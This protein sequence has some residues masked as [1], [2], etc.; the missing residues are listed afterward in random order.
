MLASTDPRC[1]SAVSTRGL[2]R[3]LLGMLAAACAWSLQLGAAQAS[4]TIAGDLDLHVP[5]SINGVGTGGG[6]GIRIGQEL[7]L[8]LVSV[9]PEIGF[10]YASFS[11]DAPPDIYRGIAGV[12]LGVGELIRFGVMAHIGF[13]YVSWKP[14]PRNYSHSGL[15]YDAG[16]FV[17]FT[18]LPL[19][20][21]GVH[22]AYNRMSDDEDQPDILHWM[23]LG[24]HGTVVL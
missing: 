10:T 6:F 24:V 15:T 8:P 4:T 20:N 22:A 18:A 13:G 23:S 5:V 2:P 12:R 3:V 16:V 1:S 17:E 9:N 19:L 11:K 7:H 21:I 14:L